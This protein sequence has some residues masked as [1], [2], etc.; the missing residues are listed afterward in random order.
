MQKNKIG[1]GIIT[2]DRPNYFEECYKSI[3]DN[4][5][6]SCVVVDD[7]NKSIRDLIDFRNEFSICLHLSFF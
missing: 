6:F 4:Y 1:V 3:K 7:G 5:D 2:C